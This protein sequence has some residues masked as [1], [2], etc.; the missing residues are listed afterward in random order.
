MK[1]IMLIL[2]MMFIMPVMGMTNITV[3]ST[4]TDMD[5]EVITDIYVDSVVDI[6]GIQI[7]ISYDPYMLNVTSVSRGNL[8]H[9]FQVMIM[10]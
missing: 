2:M 6:G 1:Y 7:D 8:F 10:N 5:K 4:V 9:D 3:N